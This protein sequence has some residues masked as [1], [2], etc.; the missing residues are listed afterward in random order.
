MWRGSTSRLSAVG[1]DTAFYRRILEVNFFAAVT[2]TLTV[3][4]GMTGRRRGVHPQLP[5]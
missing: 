5:Q 3:L 2:G 4:P 1:A